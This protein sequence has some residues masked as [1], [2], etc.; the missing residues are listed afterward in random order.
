MEEQAE[1]KGRVP[2][3]GAVGNLVNGTIFTAL[4]Y[5]ANAVGKFD[6]T[7][8]PDAIEPLAAGLIA[9]GVGI[10]VTKVLPR[11]APGSRAR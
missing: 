11:F 4:A 8:L 1:G 3:D 2:F 9:T 7:S 10:L 6:V 5:V